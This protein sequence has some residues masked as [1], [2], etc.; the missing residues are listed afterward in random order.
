MNNNRINLVIAVIFLLGGLVLYRL[1][2]LQIRKYDLYVALASSQHVAY[3]KLEPARGRI[4]IQDSYGESKL[5]PIATNK[6]FALVYAVPKDIENPQE[7]AEQ[8]K[9]ETLARIKTSSEEDLK[10]IQ[11][12]IEEQEKVTPLIDMNSMVKSPIEEKNKIENTKEQLPNPYDSVPLG[13][14]NKYESGHILIK[15]DKNE[16]TKPTK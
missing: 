6:D 12:N 10:K 7:V 13:G 2:D 3:S 15:K 14:Q 1:Y 9:Q 11:K 4:F 16:T 8:K 5:Y